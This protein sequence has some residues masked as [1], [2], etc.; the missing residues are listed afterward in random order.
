MAGNFK[1]LTFIMQQANLWMNL[2]HNFISWG[3]EGAPLA[4]KELRG[5]AAGKE[6]LVHSLI[7]Q[8]T[9]RKEG[10]ECLAEKRGVEESNQGT[11][12]KQ[13]LMEVCLE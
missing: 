6:T 12:W 11:V 8:M 10:G 3:A 1:S 4:E 2:R 7:K 5:C 13:T 9:L